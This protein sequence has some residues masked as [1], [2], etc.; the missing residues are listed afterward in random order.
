MVGRSLGAMRLRRRYGVYPLAAH[1]SNQNIGRQLDDLVVRVGDTLLL[2]GARRGYRA[3]GRRHGPGRRRR[4]PTMRAY[5]RRHAPIAIGALAG[6]VVLAALGV[7][8]ILAL[9]VVAVAV[10]LLTRCID[11]DEAF[12]FVEG[13]LLALIFA[14]LAVGAA[15]ESSGAVGAD[16]RLRSQPVLTGLPPFLVVLIAL[17]AGLV[18]DRAGV[19]QCGGGDLHPDRHRAGAMPCGSIRAAAGGGGDVRRLGGILDA[20]RLS[21]QH[22]GL[23]AGR[24]SVHRLHA[25]RHSAEPAAGAGRLGADPA[26]LAAVQGGRRDRAGAAR[27]LRRPPPRR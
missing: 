21:D 24:L 11:A 19:E 23:R 13:R 1:R 20:D 6:V 2:E 16:R 15:L 27:R 8:P 14:M 12:S 26:A 10:V 5:R 17:S 18:A 7:A 4:Q 3:A 22:A 25:D 9:A